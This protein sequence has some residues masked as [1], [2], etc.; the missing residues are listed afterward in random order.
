MVKTF[1]LKLKDAWG[2]YKWLYSW[3]ECGGFSPARPLS[4]GSVAEAED[5]AQV[6][7]IPN[8][9]IEPIQEELN[10][11]GKRLLNG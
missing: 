1:G 4:F 11:S 6:H 9:V 3:N 10:T 2:D 5:Y 7:E 8:F